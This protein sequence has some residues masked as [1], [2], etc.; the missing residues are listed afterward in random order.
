MLKRER[1]R[2]GE[3]RRE[4]G[5]GERREGEGG[6][7]QALNGSSVLRKKCPYVSEKKR[8]S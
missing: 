2:G 5:G 8:R 1:E 4:R 3:E 7:E 6:K